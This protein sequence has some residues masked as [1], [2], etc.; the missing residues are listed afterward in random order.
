VIRANPI[1]LL[2]VFLFLT[3]GGSQAA[4]LDADRECAKAEQREHVVGRIDFWKAALSRPLAQRFGAAP[5]ELAD[6]VRLDNI[7]NGFPE[8]PRP[9][10]IAAD[11]QRDLD[12]AFAELPASLKRALE[13][14]LAGVY[15]LQGLGSTGFTDKILDSGDRPVAA[16]VVLDMDLLAGRK[17]NQWA[18]WKENTPFRS[19]GAT[20]LSAT[21]ES[22][23]DDNRKN[24]IQY[25]LLHELGH[26]LSL[27]GP[28]H[29]PWW[30]DDAAVNPADYPFFSLS[31]HFSGRDGR[32]HSRFDDSFRLRG[33]I[34]Y[35]LGG[36]LD[37]DQMTEVY[38]Q[39][40]ATDFPSLYAA[41]NPFDDFAESFV[42]Y[43]HTLL[44]RKP[45]EIRIDRGNEN[46][47]RFQSCWGTPRCS[48]KQRFLEGFIRSF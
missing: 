31:W 1:L 37:A 4:C 23:G 43:V 39:L 32:Y 10:A 26:V 5:A 38:T 18:T 11:F 28:I 41:T 9:A 27:A 8:R 21:I 15:L 34:A 3:A 47:R 2:T 36:K 33:Q 14:R 24:A 12:G 30:Q 29:P 6:Y 35:Y 20:T 25:I 7:A 45:F 13:S 17:A 16:Y 19:G 42:V 46:L 40:E 48:E 22:A 44:L